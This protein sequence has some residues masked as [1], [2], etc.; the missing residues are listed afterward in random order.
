MPATARSGTSGAGRRTS[1][2]GMSCPWRRSARRCPTAARLSG[3]GSWGSTARACCARRASSASVTITA[4]SSC[5]RPHRP[6]ACRTAMCSACG[7]TRCSTSTSRG[8]D[9][10]AGAT[11]ASP[12]RS[13]RTSGSSSGSRLPCA[14][15]PARN[16]ARRSSSSP[17]TDAAGSPR[18]CCQASVSARRLTGCRTASSPWGC[19]RSATSST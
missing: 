16:A 1:T 12:E 2:P 3:A 7:P 13:R 19:G 15:R 5:C 18:P 11:P 17:A 9:R 14:T 4:A 10:T 8:T 6:S